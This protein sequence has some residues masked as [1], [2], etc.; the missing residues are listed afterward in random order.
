MSKNFAAAAGQ[1]FIKTIE[2]RISADDLL[3]IRN[4]EDENARAYEGKVLSLI[5]GKP[6][7]SWPHS[8]GVRMLL[9]KDQILHFQFKRAGVLFEF[10]GLVD[11][12]ARAPQPLMT[13]I[14][15]SQ[16]QEVQRRLNTRISCC[17]A[18]EIV[19][20]IREN[21]EDTTQTSVYFKT[22][23]SDLS[24]G[25][26]AV[27]HLKRIP[28]GALLEAA[29]SLPDGGPDIKVPCRSVYS[30]EPQDEQMMFRTG[31]QF[32]AIREA[33]RARIIRYLHKAQMKGTAKQ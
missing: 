25:G 1:E 11:D 14:I 19:G 30:D 12:L 16:I 2:S 28:G 24:A 17:L 3:R 23:T 21:P 15:S 33:D 4:T 18:V 26:L 32:L 20:S 13:I 10:S 5:E 8:S 31:L 29:L 7:I 9:H 22:V 6:T 27:K